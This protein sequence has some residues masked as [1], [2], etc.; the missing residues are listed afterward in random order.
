MI[1]QY[2]ISVKSCH[3]YLIHDEL[4][5]LELVELEELLELDELELDELD[6]LE[7]LLELDE[8]ELDELELDELDELNELDEL[9]ELDETLLDELELDELDIDELLPSS[10]KNSI[11]VISKVLNPLNSWR[12]N[13]FI[14]NGSVYDVKL[15]TAVPSATNPGSLSCKI[16]LLFESYSQR[17]L[18]PVG[19]APIVILIFVGR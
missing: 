15:N 7:E 6:E 19:R 13:S 4:D 12:S 1:F 10:V 11:L 9:D 8:L 16:I 3:P 18:I 17:S 5:E 2:E 14:S